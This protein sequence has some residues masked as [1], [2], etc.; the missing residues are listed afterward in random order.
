[1]GKTKSLTEGKPWKV[2][3]TFSLP[4]LIGYLFQQFY[5][6][7]DAMI[8]GKYL[9]E[10]AFAAVGSTFSLTFMVLMFASGCALGFSV[11][12]SQKFGAM[13]IHEVRRSLATGILLCSIITIILTSFSLPFLGFLLKIMQTP[14]EIFAD[15]YTYLFII[16]AGMFTNIFYNYFCCVLRAIGNNKYPLY[17]LIFGT[18][19]NIGLDF[20]FIV[21]FKLGVA[22]AAIA[23]VISQFI[24]MLL[25][26]FYLFIA[27]K[28]LRLKK[29]YFKTSLSFYASHLKLGLPLGFQ[30]S[31]VA[32]G[33]FI[34]QIVLN[35]Y[36]VSAIA[37]FTAASRAD[38][39]LMQPMNAIGTA[40]ITFV[41]QN[42]GARKYKRIKT[43]ITQA[44]IMQVIIA[45][46]VGLITFLFKEE[47]IKAFI[48][49][50]TK[51]AI[52]Y[53]SK[54]LLVIS[55]SYLFVGLIFLFRNI[56]QAIGKGYT[57][58]VNGVLELLA[59]VISV[60]FLP[61]AIGFWGV[62]LSVPIAWIC[63]AS[64]L[65]IFTIIYVYKN[66]T[67]KE[68]ITMS[69]DEIEKIKKDNKL[70]EISK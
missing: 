68:D 39:F 35:S 52:D 14:G 18:I 43:G 17:F 44:I 50:P 6:L 47:F 54:Y 12:I 1:M 61:M 10:N 55:F 22:G 58:L 27:Y 40:I 41:G 15:A 9:G 36:G 62:C 46:S 34:V 38:S 21:T 48:D 33:M 64:S 20:L 8:V 31:I 19:L 65:L 60:I 7:V 57:A 4:I 26:G 23:T 66:K 45:A 70:D 5:S 30:Y 11:I 51:E 3:L 69:L 24:S 53:G 59:R 67:F 32:I 56:L 63:G 25:S 37:G 42:Y 2:I 13:K 28:E 49:A 16:F 29:R